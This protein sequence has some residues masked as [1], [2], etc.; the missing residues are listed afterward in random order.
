MRSV[1]NFP[2]GGTPTH[3]NCRSVRICLEE[4]ISMLNNTKGEEEVKLD[5]EAVIGIHKLERTSR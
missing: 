1:T 4:E 5:S 3:F 2:S